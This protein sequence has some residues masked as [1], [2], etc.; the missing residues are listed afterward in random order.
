MRESIPADV[1][2]AILPKTLF[3]EKYVSLEVPDGEATGADPI[4]AGAV[5]KQA[6]VAIEVEEVLN[7]LFPLLRTVQPGRAQRTR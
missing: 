1:T 5:I 2:A 3:G 4:Q 6:E 7:D